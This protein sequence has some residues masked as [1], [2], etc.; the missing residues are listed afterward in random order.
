MKPITTDKNKRGIPIRERKRERKEP[1]ERVIK[2]ENIYI[3]KKEKYIKKKKEY[4]WIP[5]VGVV[6]F[7]GLKTEDIK[8]WPYKS[9]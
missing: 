5:F 3:N 9:A 6:F 2:K 4:Q 1:K 7:N 8:Q